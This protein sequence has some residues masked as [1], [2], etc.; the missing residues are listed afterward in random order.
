MAY[1]DVDGSRVHFVHYEG[2]G[3]TLVLIHAWAAS[4]R[5]WDGLVSS[6]TAAGMDTVTV[7]LRGCGRSDKDFRNT[8]IDV[9]GSDIEQL[10]KELA[11]DQVV[12]NGWSLGAAV[13][14]DAAAKL[15]PHVS[16][17]V[18]TA[19]AAPR[20]TRSTDWIHGAPPEALEQ[21]LDGAARNRPA[22]LR[23]MAESM[24]AVDIGQATR[25]ALW[26]SMLDA[27][28][29]IDG[30]LRDILTLDQRGTAAAAIT[31]P[32]L[33]LAGR[34]DTFVSAAASEDAAKA[35]GQDARLVFFEESGH[36]PFLEEPE[37]YQLELDKFLKTI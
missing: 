11:L 27:A 16:G 6:R 2:D 18:L 3:P 1:M 29:C 13:A 28:P 26:I 14:V 15:A 23:G 35:F 10:V 19:G 8:S 22:T 4:S 9:L 31:S 17:L 30:A 12:L 21:M 33:L 24:F 32:V 36:A 37:K 25:D 34:K 5:S 7:D 20:M